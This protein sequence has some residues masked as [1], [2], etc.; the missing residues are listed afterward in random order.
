MFIFILVRQTPYS[1]TLYFLK[2]LTVD[3]V[4]V[5]LTLGQKIG[6]G[7]LGL[8]IIRVIYGLLTN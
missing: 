1:Q 2:L 3:R 8:I 6:L 7:F 4:T 5:S